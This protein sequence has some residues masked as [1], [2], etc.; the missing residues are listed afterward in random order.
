MFKTNKKL[1]EYKKIIHLSHD[2]L[3]GYGCQQFT[4]LAF[5]QKVSFMN[6]SYGDVPLKIKRAL[7][8]LLKQKDDSLLMISDVNLKEEDCAFLQK[9]LDSEEFSHLDVILID[10]HITGKSESEKYDWYNLDTTMCATKL[11]RHFLEENM[12]TDFSLIKDF[13]EIVNAYDMFI[14]SDV[15]NFKTGKF[16]NEI[17]FKS[18]IFARQFEN[19]KSQYIRY[20]L[21]QMALNIHKNDIML[22]EENILP[23]IKR[24]YLKDLIPKEI[25][26][27][28]TLTMAYKF[29]YLNYLYFKNLELDIVEIDNIKFKIFWNL[30]GGTFQTISHIFNDESDGSYNACI[31]IKKYGFV[32]I[33]SKDPINA[34]V[35]K[36][37]A[38]RFL[39][40]GG[41][42]CAA[43]GKIQ[44]DTSNQLSYK[45]AL[46]LFINLGK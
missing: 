19:E 43:G 36:V 30:D 25:A 3:D 4:E 6:T 39:K 12:E 34:N 29:E 41:H 2:D 15:K 5:G 45:E 44:E 42:A 11:V 17:V 27:D 16:L 13:D 1:K 21:R 8:I 38:E 22:M 14:E 35:G 7:K 40:G 20:A 31:N 24:A 23:G 32:S 10:H 26:E 28:I 9:K 18:P 46:E 37:A 33:R